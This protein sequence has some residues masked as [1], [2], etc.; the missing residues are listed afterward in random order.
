MLVHVQYR[1]NIRVGPFL[2]YSQEREFKIKVWNTFEILGQLG[3]GRRNIISNKILKRISGFRAIWSSNK[4]I[5]PLINSKVSSELVH[6]STYMYTRT[7]ILVDTRYVVHTRRMGMRSSCGQFQ[8]FCAMSLKS[9]LVS[10]PS[11]P[12]T[13]IKSKVE[14]TSWA[15]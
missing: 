6:T 10:I 7:C 2:F 4:T 12:S 15:V 9:T 5:P 14:L 13:K 8:W 11:I 1:P 3:P